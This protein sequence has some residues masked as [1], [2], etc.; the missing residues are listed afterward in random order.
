MNTTSIEIPQ[1]KH[2]LSR[3]QIEALVA[4]YK[5]SG[6]SCR[7]FA[8][9]A[10]IGVGSLYCWLRVKTQGAREVPGFAAVS[11]TGPGPTMAKGAVA[12][13]A[14]KGWQLEIPA[15]LGPEY[16]AK[17]LGALMPCLR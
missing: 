14:V 16:A 10:G 2:R 13:K 8:K 12:L 17:L 11:F 4:E 9:K 7:A 6:L 15:E 1:R 3:E 5:V